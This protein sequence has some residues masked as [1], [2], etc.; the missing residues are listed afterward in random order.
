MYTRAVFVC[1]QHIYIKHYVLYLH[2][3]LV[4]YKRRRVRFQFIELAGA[5]R[6]DVAAVGSA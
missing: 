5:R 1:T 6:E 2:N 3:V 4:E